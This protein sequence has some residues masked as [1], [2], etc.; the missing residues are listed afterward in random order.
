L[1]AAAVFFG[2]ADAA[3]FLAAIFAALRFVIY[4]QYCYA[5]YL[6]FTN[7]FTALFFC[8]LQRILTVS[9]FVAALLCCF[10]VVPAAFWPPFFLPRFG[11]QFCTAL[12]SSFFA[13]AML[14]CHLQTILTVVVFVAAF[15]CFAALLFCYL[16]AIK[17]AI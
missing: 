4:K 11:H 13:A 5:A 12:W 14:F 6:S 15:C 9:I 17:T 16:Q 2:C 8:Y 10:L 7:N 3:A 1:V